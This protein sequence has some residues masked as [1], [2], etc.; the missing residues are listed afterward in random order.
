MVDITKPSILQRNSIEFDMPVEANSSSDYLGIKGIAF[1]GN[2]SYVIE[3]IGGV[4]KNTIPNYSLKNIYSNDDISSIE[5]FN[6]FT[7][8]T[9]NRTVRGDFTYI[10]DNI[11]TESWKIYNITDGTTVLRTI[12]VTHTYTG[13]DLTKTEVS[14][15]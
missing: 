8:T 4:I 13:D 9:P 5:I 15:V 11:T 14:E 3:K 1:E 10:G 12:T 7:Q 2:A 6:G